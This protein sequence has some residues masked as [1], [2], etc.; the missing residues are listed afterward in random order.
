MIIFHINDIYEGLKIYAIRSTLSYKAGKKLKSI[1]SIFVTSAFVVLLN[2]CSATG[3]SFMAAGS[4]PTDKGAIYF[5]RPKAFTGGAVSINLVDNGIKFSTIQNGQYIRY[6]AS[7]GAHKF[8]TSTSAIDKEI[9]LNIEAGKTYYV[10][11]GIRQGMWIGTWFL[12]RV[13][14]EEALAELRSCCKSGS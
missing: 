2:G 11:T 13:F 8:H 9:N 5:Y 1:V 14:P 10:R 4:A 12:T 3:A 6:L 7:P